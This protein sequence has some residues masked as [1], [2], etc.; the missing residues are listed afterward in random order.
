MH[1]DKVKRQSVK[2]LLDLPNV[3]PATAKDLHLLGIERP[4]QL[5]GQ[6]PFE[7]YDRLCN[8]THIRHDLCVIDVFLAI[9]DFA[10]GGR[11][12]PWWHFTEQRKRKLA[13]KR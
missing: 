4:D 9:V 1:P 11:P 3:G 6:D 13:T 5:A 2:S 12:Q 7:M 8:L 10:N